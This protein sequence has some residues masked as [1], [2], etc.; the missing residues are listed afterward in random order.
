MPKFIE[1]HTCTYTYTY[2]YICI[3]IYTYISTYTHR[4]VCISIY[5]PTYLSTYLSMY[6]SVEVSIYLSIYL[7]PPRP[8][9][10]LAAVFA[11]SHSRF[12]L[13]GDFSAVDGWSF[14][15]CPVIQESVDLLAVATCCGPPGRRLGSM[16]IGSTAA[17]TSQKHSLVGSRCEAQ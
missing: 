2:M 15:P 12:F 5:L 4:N 11:F 13:T 8:R 7:C 3:Y 16:P 9:R 14:C 1:T 17:L 6:L 10:L